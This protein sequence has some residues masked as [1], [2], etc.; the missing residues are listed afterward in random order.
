LAVKAKDNLSAK[1]TVVSEED[2]EELDNMESYMCGKRVVVCTGEKKENAEKLSKISST[3]TSAMNKRGIQ[4][5]A[6]LEEIRIKLTKNGRMIWGH[7]SATMGLGL[8]ED[9]NSIRHFVVAFLNSRTE[10]KKDDKEDKEKYPTGFGLIKCWAWGREYKMNEDGEMQKVDDV[11]KISNWSLVKKDRLTVAMCAIRD[12]VKG[13]RS[14]FSIGP[15]QADGTCL[16]LTCQDPR[17]QAKVAERQKAADAEGPG[18]DMKRWKQTEALGGGGRKGGAGGGEGEFGGAGGGEGGFGRAGGSEGGLGGAGGSEGGFGGA[19]GSSKASEGAEVVWVLPEN[20]QVVPKTKDEYID[21]TF[22]LKF[23]LA[24]QR[25]IYSSKFDKVMEEM[26]SLKAQVQSTTS[27]LEGYRHD[28]EQINS[29]KAQVQS[30]TSVLETYHSHHKEMSASVEALYTKSFATAKALGVR[31]PSVLMSGD[32][33]AGGPSAG[34]ASGS[35]KKRAHAEARKERASS[36]GD[37]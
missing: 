29:F 28:A 4:Y 27:A 16:S 10:T 35:S 19:G 34:G 26:N 14:A 5:A 32:A 20:Y 6:A 30:T 2:M 13:W 12:E 23:E 1:A 21:E 7:M 18:S 11:S 36:S 31:N 9:N 24:E 22:N 37:E 8:K 3:M 17:C 25:K 15:L 33:S